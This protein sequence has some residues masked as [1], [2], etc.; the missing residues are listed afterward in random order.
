MQ[1]CYKYRKEDGKFKMVVD[2]FLKLSMLDFLRFYLFERER[3][4]ESTSRE[5]REKQAP[6]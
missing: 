1:R 3:E 5:E 4:G 2:T 6:C